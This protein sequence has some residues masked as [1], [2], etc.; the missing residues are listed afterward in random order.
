[1]ARILIFA[2]LIIFSTQIFADAN[3][4]EY[5]GFT[6]GD[7][8]K[9]PRGADGQHHIT[10]A[11][12]YVVDPGR[13]AHHM[14]SMSIY[15][16]PKSSVIGSIFGEWYFSSKRSAKDFANQY[17]S[18]LEQKYGHWQRKGQSLTYGDYQLWVD[19]EEKSPYSEY[20]PSRK[21]SRVAVGLIFAPE[22]EGRNEWMAQIQGDINNREAST[23]KVASQH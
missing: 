15:V 19:I 8:F 5:L 1:M 16:S 18:T 7:R 6:L 21:K 11:I 10:G 12:V 3:D 22:S 17:L 2:S 13:Q 14:D 9:V 23:E 20:W 4:G